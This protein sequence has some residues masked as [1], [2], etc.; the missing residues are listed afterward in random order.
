[1]RC[2]FS[3]AIW[4]SSVVTAELII[5]TEYRKCSTSALFPAPTNNSTISASTYPSSSSSSATT[6]STSTARPTGAVLG[7]LGP[8]AAASASTNKVDFLFWLEFANVIRSAA[9]INTG[10]DTAF[11]VGSDAQIGPLA[12][13]NIDQ[14]FTNQGIFQLANTLLSDNSIYYQPGIIG[15]VDALSK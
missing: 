7:G 15:Y 8:G 14:I 9:G 6:V 13:D 5:I 12:V 4:L 3:R 1:M 10:N 2:F 11:F